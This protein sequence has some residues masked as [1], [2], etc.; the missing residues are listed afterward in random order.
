MAKNQRAESQGKMLGRITVE[1]QSRF[2]LQKCSKI[3][4]G[5][6]VGQ[7]H[8]AGGMMGQNFNKELK[9]SNFGQCTVWNYGGGFLGRIIGWNDGPELQKGFE[10]QNCR[11]KSCQNH[12]AELH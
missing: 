7:N 4:K 3:L 12:A 11:A 8:K 10:G 1:S 5:R 6:I 2:I 9:G